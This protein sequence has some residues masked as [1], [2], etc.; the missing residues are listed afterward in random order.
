VT[1]HLGAIEVE[2]VEHLM[3]ERDRY[4]GCTKRIATST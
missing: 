3:L 1:P 4:L 2:V